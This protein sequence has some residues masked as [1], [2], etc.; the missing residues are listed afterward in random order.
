MIILHVE[1]RHKT[2]DR[3]DHIRETTIKRQ[4][5]GGLSASELY[6]L[7]CSTLI[8]LEAKNR[9]VRMQRNLRP[10]DARAAQKSPSMSRP[11]KSK[12]C[13]RCRARKQRC[14]GPPA[15]RNCVSADEGQS[16]SHLHHFKHF[17]RD[18]DFYSSKVSSPT[19]LYSSGFVY[20]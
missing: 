17:K 4:H 11:R 19:A 9:R 3:Q 2:Q 7:V 12:A 15:C 18:L 8:E 14:E 5:P 10:A 1:T 20:P 13:Q 6:Q 16:F